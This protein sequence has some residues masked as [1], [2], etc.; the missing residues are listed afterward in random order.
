MYDACALIERLGKS[1]YSDILI[2]VGTSDSF[3]TA[4]QLRP[5]KFLEACAAVKQ[6]VSL[7]YQGGY[8][9]SY[10]FVS[11]FVEDHVKFHAQFLNL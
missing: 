2:D 11:T 8:D 4:G 7:R 5:D 3:L 6:P 1:K 10:Y 9:H